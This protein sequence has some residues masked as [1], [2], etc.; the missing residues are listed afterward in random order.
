METRWLYTTSE[1]M[2]SLREASKD[3]CIIPMG[4]VEKHGLHL[5]LGTDILQASR[6]AYLASQ[7]E[8]VC[9]FPDFTFG[10][11]A[12][13]VP[14]A[15]PGNISVSL[16]LQMQLLEELCGQIA[17]NGFQKIMIFN[18][19]GG[20]VAW[21]S[22]FLRKIENKPHNYVLVNVNIKCAVMERMA[23]EIREKG[24]GVYAELTAE[25]EILILDCAAK[26]LKDGH[27]GYSETA[28]MLG[29]APNSVY[30][31][32]LGV[33]S[34]KSKNLTGIYKGAGIQIRDNGWGINFP[35]WID[36]DDPVGCNERI[37]KVALQ[38]EAERLAN[39][40]KIIKE[41]KNLIK[42]HN[43]LWGVKL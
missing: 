28:Y 33:V 7:M 25:D 3:T 26:K 16:E 38:L 14:T 10:D 17:R 42:W 29:T 15:P 40:I 32:K 31:E 41:D 13:N 36:S 19:H 6:I 35:D 37:G 1:N 8:T 22:A 27:S 11:I 2:E 34:G 5:P 20:N 21:I 24:S 43:E 4:C 9:V 12:E 30:M 18:G 23:R 39:A